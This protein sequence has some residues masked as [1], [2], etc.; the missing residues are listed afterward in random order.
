MELK[1]LETLE[2]KI[3]KAASAIRSLRQEKAAIE[4]RL[5]G[6][7]EEIEDLRARIEE[8][9]GNGAGAEAARELE[10]LRAERRDILARVER[11]LA[12]LDESEALAGRQEDLLA[13]VDED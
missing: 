5:A 10:S 3:R 4:K 7:E 8:A 11:M 13:T 9:E 2:E 1:K 12:L 6:R